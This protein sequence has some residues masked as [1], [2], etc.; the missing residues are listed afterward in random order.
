VKD[1]FVDRIHPV[2]LKLRGEPGKP[3]FIVDENLSHEVEKRL[4]AIGYP[5]VHVTKL[6]KKGTPDRVITNYAEKTNAH[7]LTRDVMSFPEPKSGGDRICIVD[8]PGKGSVPE[9]LKRLRELGLIS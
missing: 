2:I 7:V 8:V 9:T 5:A 6:F 3:F 4:R 1:W